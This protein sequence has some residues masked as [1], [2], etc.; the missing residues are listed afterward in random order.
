MSDDEGVSLE[1]ENNYYGRSSGVSEIEEDNSSHFHFNDDAPNPMVAITEE[2]KE[3]EDTVYVA[4]GKSQSSMDALSW[5]LNNLATPSTI[6]YLIHVFPEIK[7]LP[8]PLGVGMIP[9]DQV[10]PELVESYMAQERGKR[11]ELLNK[12]LQLCSASKVKVDTILIESDLIAKAIIDLIPI[13]QI[14]KVVI[15]ASKSHTRKMRSRKGSGI[16]DQ[17]LQN[18]PES[19]DVSIVCE[20]KEVNEQI[21]RAIA[22][23]TSMSQKNKHQQQNTSVSWETG[24]DWYLHNE[25]DEEA[26]SCS[27]GFIGFRRNQVFDCSTNEVNNEDSEELFE[28]NLK[29]PLNT[30]SE[31][32]IHNNNDRDVVHVAVDHVGESSMEA[33][34]WTLKHAVTP[35]TT[36]YLIHFKT[37]MIPDEKIVGKFPRSVVNAEYVKFHLTQEKGKRKLLLQEF[38]DLCLDSKVK[39]EVMLI[40]GDNVAKAI[41]DLVRDHDIRK[42]MI[43]IT[44]SNL[45]KSVSRRRNGMAD[46][47]LRNAPEMCD[48]KIICDG[49]EVIDQ[50]IDC[51]SSCDNSSFRAAQEGNESCGFVS[52]M[53][54]VPN[55]IWIFR[56]RF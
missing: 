38:I 48:V 43:G 10:S 34:L 24:R 51:I 55:P 54:F 29:E 13:L 53:R 45:R 2:E 23:D 17:I 46:K 36:V 35:S 14:R 32:Y 26:S 11:R 1:V 19:C 37:L 25:P 21:T 49:K 40:E 31:D 7:L 12:F 6:I 28:I 5:T 56:P 52:L 41:T 8:N 15:G 16:A 39:V 3:E 22:T 33:L 4:V 20:G 18:A 30:I 47:I 42:L 27:W 50:I 9:K 44:K